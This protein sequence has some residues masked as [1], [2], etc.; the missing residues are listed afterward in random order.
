MLVVVVVVG[1]GVAAR[2]WAG[3]R[4]ATERAAA[5]LHDT[6]AE[7]ART[8]HDVDTASADLDAEQATLGD[9]LATL[10]TRRS[11]ADAAQD[12]LDSTSLLLTELR[13]QLSEATADLEDRTTRLDALELCLVG[14]AEALNQAA[15]GD[16][17]GLMATVRDVEGQCA[18]AGV[19]L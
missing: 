11:E 5:T 4:D 8:R 10:D 16:T 6:R 15:V 19:D 18:E 17:A 13:A 14:V 1:L 7:L 2:V 12:T 3:T 9:E